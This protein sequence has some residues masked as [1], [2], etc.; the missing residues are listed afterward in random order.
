MKDLPSASFDDFLRSLQKEV[1]GAQR[2]IQQ[3]HERLVRRYFDV[4]ADGQLKAVKWKVSTPGTTIRG[5][6]LEELIELPLLSLVPPVQHKIVEA[7]LEFEADVEESRRD[8]KD[9][10]GSM[11]LVIKK[12]NKR[13]K[14]SGRQIKI[15]MLGPQ[16]GRV[17]VY[18]DGILFKTLDGVELGG[19]RDQNQS[20]FDNIN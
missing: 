16:P 19:E 8:K 17:E 18:V 13:K 9:G 3:Q 6:G 5:D 7:S 20:L 15:S 1:G 14:A 2:A 4:D 11:V 12:R 10:R